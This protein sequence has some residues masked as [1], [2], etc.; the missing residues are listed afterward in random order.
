MNFTLSRLGSLIPGR[1]TSRDVEAF[2][3]R[4]QNIERRS[5]GV[6]TYYAIQVYNPFE[7]P[8]RTT[9]I[10]EAPRKNSIRPS[11]KSGATLTL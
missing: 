7:D 8:G 1:S 10:I 4:P 6:V 2:F 3:G 9:I 5:D 11:L